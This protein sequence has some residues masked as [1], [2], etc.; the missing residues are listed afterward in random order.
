[1]PRLNE[2]RCGCRGALPAAR[3]DQL[4]G[5]EVA[6]SVPDT[7]LDGALQ[8]RGGSLEAEDREKNKRVVL[9]SVELLS[10]AAGWTP[11]TRGDLTAKGTG[12]RAP[13]SGC[14]HRLGARGAIGAMLKESHTNRSPTGPAVNTGWRQR[15]R[16]SSR[17]PRLPQSS[18][19]SPE[20]FTPAISFFPP[21]GF[22]LTLSNQKIHIITWCRDPDPNIPIAWTSFCGD[23]E[24]RRRPDLSSDT[25]TEG[26]N[27]P[28]GQWIE[29]PQ[30]RVPVWG[31]SVDKEL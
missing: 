10:L 11:S 6:Y 8:G 14:K 1:M 9:P 23:T 4:L 16:W 7:Q 5:A 22:V 15:P 27:S 12:V 3:I 18:R 17:R 31:S 25:K 26:V 21:L 30:T 19:P 2:A 28:P 24:A 13:R 29:L 20:Y